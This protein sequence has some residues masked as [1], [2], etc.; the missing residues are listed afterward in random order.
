LQRHG[1]LSLRLSFSGLVSYPELGSRGDRGIL[2]KTG[3]IDSGSHRQ[4]M[5]ESAGLVKN[6]LGFENR[7]HLKGIFIA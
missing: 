7:V 4:N 3:S 2:G 5:L 6:Y 1:S